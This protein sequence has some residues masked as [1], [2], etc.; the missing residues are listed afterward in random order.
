MSFLYRVSGLRIASD[1]RFALLAGVPDDG[2][3]PDVT[4]RFAPV[5]EEEGRACGH[6]RILGPGRL[7]L[8]IPDVVRVRIAGGREMTVDMAP[9]AAEGAL[10][11][12]LFGPAFAALLYQR[13]QIPLHAGAV[14]LDGEGAVAV[15][16]HS[17]AGKST[18]TRALMRAGHAL[19]CDDQLVVDA[20]TGLAQA[21]FPALKL[22]GGALAH[23]GEEIGAR[24]QVAQGVDKYHVAAP[25]GFD[26]S[27]ARLRAVCILAPDAEIR[28]PSLSRMPVPEAVAALGM[29][30][31]HA[32]VADAIGRRG[33]L[34]RFSAALA[35][36]VP[37]YLLSR[38]D[39]LAGLDLVIDRVREAGRTRAV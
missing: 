12:Y 20:A 9:G 38:P 21:G 8:A 3:A 30:A 5:P 34:F 6:F 13:G 23:F 33:D 19:F 27:P 7:D 32:Y 25:G 4:I 29:L 35:G 18:T 39:D 22:W 16:G 26:L 31:H 17:R 24:A 36:R 1:R 2:G 28:A 15:A 11:T 14:R 37:V 10:Q